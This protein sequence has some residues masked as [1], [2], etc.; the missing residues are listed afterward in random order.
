MDSLTQ[1]NQKAIDD[2]AVWLG[3]Q[4]ERVL[5]FRYS[6]IYAINLKCFRF[7]HFQR[8]VLE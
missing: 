8:I 5:R 7:P 6:F 3:P 4:T 2:K 1:D